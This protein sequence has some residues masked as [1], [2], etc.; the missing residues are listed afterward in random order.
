M[1][2]LRIHRDDGPTVMSTDH[3]SATDLAAYIDRAL[4]PAS[5][6]RVEVHL[7]DCVRCRDE[8]AACARLEATAPTGRRWSAIAA[9]ASV[10]AASVILAAVLRPTLER[11]RGEASRQ[12]AAETPVRQLDIASPPDGAE[13]PRDA[14]R[15]FWHPDPDAA[16]YRV[17]V[18][19]ATGAPV[20]SKETP[21]TMVAPPRDRTSVPGAEYF[22]RVEVARLDGTTRTSRTSGFRV[23]VR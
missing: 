10:L 12:R 4:S 19:T 23:A 18:T 16:A 7:S 1:R 13:V 9:V 22:W 11:S 14:V 15:L 6:E 8:L 17:V 5:R 3:L 20:W 21:D 2:A